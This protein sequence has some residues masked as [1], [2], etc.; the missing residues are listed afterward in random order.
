LKL[1]RLLVV[2]LSLVLFAACGGG[3]TPNQDPLL[4]DSD[5]D[6]A[7]VIAVSED[8]SLVVQ[9]IDQV[10]PGAE[11]PEQRS[12]RQ[13]QAVAE[14]EGYI[15]VSQ[16][17]GDTHQILLV[18]AENDDTTLVYEGSREVQS[19]AVNVEGGFVA[20]TAANAQGAQEVFGF[21]LNGDVFGTA[22]QL[23]RLTDTPESE[24]DVSMSLDGLVLAWQGVGSEDAAGQTVLVRGEL[25]AA[26]GSP[27]IA[28]ETISYST[29]DVIQPSISG[30]GL[31]TVFVSQV[32]FEGLDNQFAL[33]RDFRGEEPY[34]RSVYLS[35]GDLANPSV[36]G[37]NEQILFEETAGGATNLVYLDVLPGSFLDIRPGELTHPYLTADGNFA[38]YAENGEVFTGPAQPLEDGGGDEPLEQGGDFE[39]VSVSWAKALPAPPAPTEGTI[40]N[41]GSTVGKPTFT[42]PDNGQEDGGL[43]DAQRTLPY[44]AFTFTPMEDGTY[45]FFS[46]QDFD[47]YLLLY[48]GEF[49]PEQPETN[50]IIQR[51]DVTG[52]TEFDTKLTGSTEYTLVTTGCGRDTT[53]CGPPEGNFTNTITP[54]IAGP[55]DPPLIIVFSSTQNVLPVGGQTAFSW[56]ISSR[57]DLSCTI[58]FGD[59]TPAAQIDACAE[60]TSVSHTY[61]AAGFYKTTLTATNANGESTAKVFPTVTDED[62]NAF[63]ITLV[64]ADDN[65]TDAQRQ[66][67]VDAADRWAEVI[68]ADISNLDGGPDG[69]PGPLDGYSCAG[70]PAFGGV[71]DDLVIAVFTPQIDGPRSILGSAGPCIA[72]PDTFEN[73][74]LPLYGIMRFDS[75]DIG[76]L[77]RDGELQSVIL[78]EMGHVLGIGTLWENNG[79][80]T[81]GVSSGADPTSDTYDPRYV[82][83]AAVGAYQQLLTDAGRDSET[84]VPAANTGGPGTREGHWRE[85]TFGSELMTGFLSGESQPLSSLTA[86]GLADLTYTI[87]FDVV[88]AFELPPLEGEGELNTAAQPRGYDIVLPLPDQTKWERRIR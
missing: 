76:V 9:Q 87:N 3:G 8:T 17:S 39:A 81:G 29:Y 34:T 21:D 75:A 82:G 54:L 57:G 51:D 18:N 67:F 85:V 13:P 6:G 28:L 52:S 84:T 49:D 22:E 41:E 64:F 2:L 40:V 56:D 53:F 68:T 70:E 43:T 72:R 88:D 83:P 15:I 80:I 30:D 33:I 69:E 14:A 19:V 45:S 46:E 32:D 44:E 63:D 11:L 65:L 86:S 25:D 1:L 66:V 36:S 23:L 27:S 4:G 24:Q 59:G 37:S 73:P 74:G 42:R 47:G 58:D 61:T 50:L 35:D 10:E 31:Y 26:G 77:E 48:E 20:F 79:F 7:P 62:P 12:A 60:T 55:N 16:K 5:L 78:H 71:I 38:V